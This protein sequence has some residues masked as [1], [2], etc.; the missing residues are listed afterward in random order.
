MAWEKV[1]NIIIIQF[2]TR[3]REPVEVCSEFYQPLVK[4]LLT[5]KRL[6]DKIPRFKK[7]KSEHIEYLRDIM[8][9]PKTRN[10]PL[11]IK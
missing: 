6:K 1:N 2:I 9:S 10:L 5:G 8:K 11:A 7:V 4:F 3:F